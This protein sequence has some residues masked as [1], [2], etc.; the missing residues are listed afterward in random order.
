MI[1]SL[2]NSH[3][4]QIIKLNKR[5]TR[6]A[7]Q[8]TIVEGVREAERALKSGI[9]PRNAFICPDLI[10]GAEAQAVV[11]KLRQMTQVFEVS[12]AVYQKLA[13]RGTTGGVLLTI[14]YLTQTLDGLPLSQ[15]PF[16]AIVD[17]V[18]KPGNLGAILR[19]ADAAGVDGL[20]LTSDTPGGTDIHNPNVIRASLGALF[21]VPVVTASVQ[22]VI[23]WLRENKIQIVATTPGAEVGYTAVNL[24][25]PT[26][27]IM[28]S[29]AHG[30]TPTWLNAAD[31]KVHIPMHGLM[32]SLNLSTATAL[33]LYEVVRQ[34][35]RI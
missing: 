30:L 20:I 24:Q 32:D 22:A 12:T 6:D 15:N 26:A 19:T 4:K 1:T 33:L 21:S 11:D 5:R 8:L 25:S 2:Q 16:L 14:P 7:E 17:G 31:Q 10:N 9:V 35:N 3:V 34:R 29:E 27:I 28:G 18:E 23:A 13:Y